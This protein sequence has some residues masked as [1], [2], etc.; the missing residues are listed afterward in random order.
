MSLKKLDLRKE[1][2]LKNF[3]TIKIGGIAKYF[4]IA[5]SEEDLIN[6]LKSVD[7]YYLLGRGSNLLIK[8]S[9]ITKPIIKLGEEFS[10]IKKHKDLIEIGAAT[11]LSCILKYCIKNK[12]GGFSN[13]AG[14][15]ATLGGII[16]MNASAFGSTLPSYLKKVEVINR[17]GKI[18]TIEREDISFG[19]RTSS[20]EDF[21]ILRAYFNLP[22][23]FKLKEEVSYI[24]KKRYTFQDFNFPS[25]GC[26][27]KN[28]KEKPAGLLIDLCGLKGKEKNGAQISLKHANFIINKNN[29]KYNDVDY[30]IGIIKDNVYKKFNIELEEEIRRWS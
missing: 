9:T 13:L 11:T 5:H 1:V 28:P 22:M 26:V 30:L 20:L 25:C 29:A 18:F 14:I 12:L 24:L 10:Y 2:N 23:S 19:Y 21:I 27:F 7:D 3:T 6:I 15:P 8:D 16:F 17:R 4:F